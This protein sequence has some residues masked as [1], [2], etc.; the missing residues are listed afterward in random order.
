M[1]N[2][3]FA[4]EFPSLEAIPIKGSGATADPEHLIANVADMRIGK[5]FK[6]LDVSGSLKMIYDFTTAETISAVVIIGHNFS[7]STTELK[8]QM[9][10]SSSW[11]TP[12]LDEDIL[13]SLVVGEPLV[14][15]LSAPHSD[16]YMRVY[17]TDESNPDGVY[18]VSV[19]LSFDYW[20][21]TKNIRDEYT[22]ES[23]DPSAVLHVNGGSRRAKH[24]MKF[25][26]HTVNFGQRARTEY[27]SWFEIIKST[28]LG[29]PMLFI[30]DADEPIPA[31][32][33][34]IIYGYFDATGV[35]RHVFNEEYTLDG[36][37][38]SEQVPVG[39]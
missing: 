37:V 1:A 17:V 23:I 11:S 15:F 24:R 8:F 31:V 9:N 5:I 33:E 26:R 10:D 28:G 19:V 36:V 21:P 30:K 2:V 27:D 29:D 39:T 12:N 6:T 18:C 22:I 35:L 16:R 20:E 7:A 13:S 32:A 3:R 4:T 34:D 25:D 14:H 38:F